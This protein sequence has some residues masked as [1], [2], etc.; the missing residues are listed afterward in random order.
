M[1]AA[2]ISVRSARAGCRRQSE[3]VRRGMPVTEATSMSLRPSET[4]RRTSKYSSLD[5][6]ERM[7]AARA[8]RYTP[9][10]PRAW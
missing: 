2:A 8:D 10:A 3:M 9:G 6:I 1:A 7:F 4:S 5:R